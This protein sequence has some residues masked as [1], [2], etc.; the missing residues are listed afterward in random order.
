M[1]VPGTH[2][3]LKLRHQWRIKRLS[4]EEVEAS[5]GADNVKVL[6]G[7]TGDG[8]AE[9]TYC[10]HKGIPPIAK[11][12]LMLQVMYFANSYGYRNDVRD[13]QRLRTLLP[14]R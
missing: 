2:R 7:R 4:D 14:A 6:Y 5:Y 10:L 1:F 11:D 3:T 12:R 13:P 8:F 9:D